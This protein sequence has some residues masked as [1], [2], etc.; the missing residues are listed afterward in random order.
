M[1]TNFFPSRKRHCPGCSERTVT[2]KEQE[3]TEYYHR[4]VVAYLIV[5]P[6]PVPMDVEFYLPGEGEVAAAERLL[7]RVVEDYPRFF[8][9]VIADALYFQAPFTNL[10]RQHDKHIIVT[11]KNEDRLLYQDAE[12]VFSLV[13]PERWRLSSRHHIRGWDA[14][15]FTSFQGVD[16]PMRVVHT[17]ETQTQHTQRN[18]KW[19]DEIQVHN[20]WWTTTVPQFMMPTRV[21]R[22]AAHR[23][24][25][26]EDRLFHALAT[27]WHLN[28]CFKHDPVAI[29]NFILVLFTAYVLLEAFYQRNLKPEV[30][31]RLTLCALGR[32]LLQGLMDP[33][34]KAPWL[35]AV[36]VPD[37]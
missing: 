30:R 9:A 16:E 5:D 4:G 19:T 14:E 20:W 18:G 25:D 32:E 13:E 2:V 34:L 6:I 28:H 37:S 29:L 15:G 11:M 26:I 35:G 22:N 1:G 10:C 17:E 27:H 7:L 31:K 21:F 24:W 3:V 12:G 33:D 23:R 8:D 36:A